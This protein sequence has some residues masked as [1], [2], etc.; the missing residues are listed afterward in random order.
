MKNYLWRQI[1][2]VL[3]CR[4]SLAIIYLRQPKGVE[5]NQSSLIILQNFGYVVDRYL[6]KVD[7]Q[8]ISY[9]R[10]KKL[11]YNQYG[12]IEGIQQIK[13]HCRALLKIVTRLKG[14]IPLISYPYLNLMLITFQVHLENTNDSTTMSSV[15]SNYLTMLIA[16]MSG[17][18]FNF[19]L[20]LV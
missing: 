9:V 2:I 11:E 1:G 7:H 14:N 8:N 12:C 4:T 13:R 10:I 3:W 17:T 20:S 18:S 19:Y 15:S 5:D 6:I 16:M